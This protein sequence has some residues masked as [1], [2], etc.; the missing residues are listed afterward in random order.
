MKVPEAKKCSV[1]D[2]EGNFV[3]RDVLGFQQADIPAVKKAKSN[4]IDK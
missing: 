4:T 3:G 1:R 2:R